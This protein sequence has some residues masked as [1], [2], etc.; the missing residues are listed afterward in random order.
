MFGQ[1]S[2]TARNEHVR[3]RQIFFGVASFVMMTQLVIGETFAQNYPTSPFFLAQ[4]AQF[5]SLPSPVNGFKHGISRVNISWGGGIP[6]LWVGEI[7][8]TEGELCQLV[9]LGT[10]PD[11][12]GSIWLEEGCVKFQAMSPKVFSGIHVTLDA[13]VTAQ[14]Q[15][16]VLDI[17]KK[18]EQIKTFSIA[19]ILKTK[20]Q[21]TLDENGNIITI[22]RVPG[23]ELSVNF[24]A[25]TTVFQPGDQ[26]QFD[27]LPRFTAFSWEKNLVLNVSVYRSRTEERLIENEYPLTPPLETQEKSVIPVTL[28]LPGEEG[29]FDIVLTTQL[30]SEKGFM[31]TGKTRILAQ[32]TV[33]CFSIFR[34]FAP[35]TNG[36]GPVQMDYRGTLVETIDTHNPT[37]WK[38][39]TKLPTLPKVGNPTFR[40]PQIPQITQL[41]INPW[42]KNNKTNNIW[43]G[44]LGSG[45]LMP[46]QGENQN[47]G[48]FSQLKPSHDP[49]VIPWEA[50]SVPIKEPEKPHFL[51]ID[52][53]SDLPQT[54]GIS[55]L[56]SNVYGGVSSN[57]IDSGI[58]VTEKVVKDSTGGRISQH[59]ILFWPRTTEPMILL[60]NKRTDQPAVFGGIRIYRAPDDFPRSISTHQIGVNNQKRLFAGYYHRPMFCENFSASKVPGPENNTKFEISDWKTFQ[61]GTERMIQYMRMIGYGGMMISVV[62]D[63]SSLYPSEFLAPTPRYD[64]GVFL[65]SGEDPVR[66]DILEVIATRFDRENMVFIPAVDFC[67]PLIALENRLRAERLAGRS[68]QETGLTLIGPRGLSITEQIGTNYGRAPYYNVLHPQVQDEMLEVIRE[69][70]RRSASHPSFGGVAIQLSP[71][72]YAMFPDETWGMD[73]QTIARFARERRLEIPG[74]GANRF[75]ERAEFIRK[76]CLETWLRWRAEQLALFYRRVRSVI[77]EM[78]PDAKLYLAGAK[79]FDSPLCQRMF[80]PSLKNPPNVYP[81][82]LYLGL[83]PTAYQD[84]PGVLF[85]RPEKV[86]S[87]DS[88]ADASFSLELSQGNI[89]QLFLRHD[90]LQGSLFYHDVIEGTIPGFDPVCPHQPSQS[91]FYVE[92]TP[93]DHQNRARF[94]AHLADSD[95]VTMFDGGRMLSLGQEDAVRE[96]IAQFQML[97]PVPFKTYMPANEKQS[98]QPI[99]FRFANTP[100]GTYCYLLNTA[101]FHVPVRTVFASQQGCRIQSLSVLRTINIPQVVPG[102]FQWSETIRPYDFL[103]VHVSDPNATPALVDVTRPNEICG[104]NGQLNQRITDL[105]DRIGFA[106]GGIIWDALQNPGFEETSSSATNLT[107]TNSTE[108]DSPST[109]SANISPQ[110]TPAKPRPS[111]GSLFNRGNSPA[112]PET[113]HSVDFYPTTHNN[114]PGWSVIGEN[115]QVTLDNTAAK[116]GNASAKICVTQTQG[117]IVSEPFAIPNSGRLFVTAWIGIPENASE[118]PLRMTLTGRA[119]NMPFSRSAMIGPTIWGQ[120]SQTTP[121]NGV[122]WC[123]VSMSFYDLPRSGGRSFQLQFELFHPGAVWIDEIQLYQLAFFEDAEQLALKRLVN[124]AVV[125]LSNDRVSEAM[126]ILEGYWARLLEECIPDVEMIRQKR[127]EVSAA[128]DLK[129]SPVPA[130]KPA[131]TKQEDNASKG[132][133]GRVKQWL[134]ERWR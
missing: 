63:G 122:R 6:Q 46:Y 102:G 71:D 52:Y 93:G 55:I 75:A 130:Q 106:R 72:G 105:I 47:P 8:L 132:I 133:I 87:N 103:V 85:L 79:M 94:V 109:T 15:F 114:I 98:L 118:L 20:Q 39:F 65:P 95:T 107:V 88:P 19:E 10:E 121:V 83:D 128:P 89:A 77:V 104:P 34:N 51:E 13:P 125:R 29:A 69:L 25:A 116:A 54:L 81:A 28:T 62:S 48:N 32:R 91:W 12:P 100:N 60:S 90:R 9:A 11:V 18:T 50:F 45:D 4:K 108:A 117:G 26:I 37:W 119:Q 129:E 82:L 112:T 56:E 70:V 84:D 35:P 110:L 2:P 101:S 36:P 113:T 57:T 124:A 23:D 96:M 61:E 58:H 3:F 97:P 126:A 73:D 115:T 21:Q 30:K 22:E 53:I 127:S 131:E 33:Q 27:V 38:R 134:P 14:L 44:A 59:R 43:Q 24:H 86:V 120:I 92:P 68:P 64:S 5:T 31:R 67:T 111:I 16:R 74:I 49:T 80:T 1:G 78:R 42:E 41:P 40:I 17:Q 123:S 99:I 76:S 66:K 7:R